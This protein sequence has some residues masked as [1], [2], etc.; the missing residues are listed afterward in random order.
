MRVKNSE[1]DHQTEEDHEE[2]S[3]QGSQ[4]NFATKNPGAKFSNKNLK[5][6]KVISTNKGDIKYSVR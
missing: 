3:E 6:S 2:N 5:S 4:K 1:S